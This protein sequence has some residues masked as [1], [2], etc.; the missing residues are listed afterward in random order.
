MLWYSLLEKIAYLINS[1]CF[2]KKNN[3]RS[4]ENYALATGGCWPYFR[5]TVRE[6]YFPVGKLYINH[7]WNSF[8]P[9]CLHVSFLNEMITHEKGL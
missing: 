2:R 5:K 7:F 1:P 4:L 9:F 8:L 6:D 3:V